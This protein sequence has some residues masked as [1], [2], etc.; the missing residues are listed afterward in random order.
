L[1]RVLITGGNGFVGSHV[2]RCLLARGN[3]VR[4]L[5]LSFDWRSAG[6]SAEKVSCDVLDY[7]GVRSA[8][9]SVD[10]IVHLAAVSRVEDAERDPETCATV[11]VRGTANVVRVARET[12]KALVFASSR[13]VYGDAERFPVDEETPKRPLSV[14][15]R[16]KLAAE[17]LVAEA[18]RREGL[19]CTIVRLSNVFGSPRDRRE[20]VV[21]TFVRQALAG[22]PLT[23]HGGAQ[24]MDFTFIDDVAE[25]IASIAENPDPWRGE[26][27]NVVSGRSHSVIDLARMVLRYT[28]SKSDFC[29]EKERSFY[30]RRFVGS[31]A[32]LDSM[33]G[34]RGAVRGLNEGLPLY[35]DRVAGPPVL[36]ALNG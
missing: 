30:A 31:S 34:R 23:I 28:H 26:D 35:V 10:A 9:E 20:R 5:D 36:E 7:D 3:E 33:V 18:G 14:Y 16:S 27:Y 13:E 12:S 11:N 4:L 22:H 32:K 1:S 25:V 17:N 6:S 21:P 2:A 29:F 19:R 8:A 24:C 15:A